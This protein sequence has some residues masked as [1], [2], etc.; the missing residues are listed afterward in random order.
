MSINLPTIGGLDSRSVVALDPYL[1]WFVASNFQDF[2]RR[3]SD[4]FDVMIEWSGNK[5]ASDLGSALP[6][7]LAQIASLSAQSP[8]IGVTSVMVDAQELKTLL[9]LPDLVK[10]VQL[11]SPLRAP[12]AL[13]RGK[14][15]ARTILAMADKSRPQYVADRSNTLLAVVDD[16]CPFAHQ[17]L[18]TK[19][20]Y[21]LRAI[22]DQDRDAD[23]AALGEPPKEFGYGAEADRAALLAHIKA[24]SE[25]GRVNEEACYQSLDYQAAVR[26]RSHGGH[27]LGM[28]LKGPFGINPGVDALHANEQ[29]DVLFVQLPRDVTNV[30]A[31]GA[32]LRAILDG[33][34][35]ALSRALPN[36]KTVRV[37]VPYGSVVGPH[38]GSSIFTQ[39]LDALIDE[40]AKAGTKL[41]VILP[42][43]NDFNE[44]LHWVCDSLDTGS[45][46]QAMLR[47]AVESE[48]PVFV[49]LW[50]PAGTQSVLISVFDPR[51][52]EVIAR[53]A[54]SQSMVTPTIERPE[55]AII[56]TGWSGEAKTLVLLRFSPT[57]QVANRGSARAGDWRIQIS[58]EEA[59]Y[60]P[61]HAY[62][63]KARGGLGSLKRANQSKFIGNP[64]SKH[65]RVSAEGTLSDAAT[66]RNS[67]VLGAHKPWKE[68]VEQPKDDGKVFSLL[69]NL[70]ADYTSAGPANGGDRSRQAKRHMPG[71]NYS[72][73]S[74]QSAWLPGFRNAGNRS[75]ATYRMNG[76]SVA[77]SYFAA[78]EGINLDRTQSAKLPYLLP[79]EFTQQGILV[80]SVTEEQERLG[81]DLLNPIA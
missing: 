3:Q 81:L 80:T 40:A 17:M 54:K 23:F 10:R 14:S 1:Y 67:I 15:V 11:A 39:A 68:W 26:V 73:P 64:S 8:P 43:G 46:C 44:A 61:L 63:S 78:L 28:Y 9:E 31:H 13:R 65:G 69:A 51:G 58:T 45:S 49:E 32:R 5:T 12:R 30:P 16:G 19:Q 33:V 2:V 76:T 24:H 52:E 35:W 56:S 55:C 72:M 59:I 53:S 18:W 34:R 77:A 57:L 20:T 71:P 79:K 29:S 48:L 7:L 4:R 60:Q 50:L 70:P 22:W 25:G 75:A 41:E 66:G 74:E 42:S 62:V 36:E 37:V 38:D 47:L 27:T 6:N 21:R